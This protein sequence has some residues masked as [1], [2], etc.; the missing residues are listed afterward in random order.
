M[1]IVFS[2]ND[3]DVFQSGF[4]D[5][6]LGLDLVSDSDTSYVFVN[7]NG[8]AVGFYGT[9]LNSAPPLVSQINLALNGQLQAQLQDFSVDLFVL[10]DALNAGI[11]G[12]FEP[13]SNLLAE[14][15]T[16]EIDASNALV[17]YDMFQN[18][19]GTVPFVFASA[20]FDVT[21]SS[22]DDIL[23]DSLGN[24][25]ING[26][27]GEDDY[28]IL[29][30]RSE[31]QV[32][33]VNGGVRITIAINDVDIIRNVETFVFRDGEFTLDEV[34]N[35]IAQNLTGLESNDTLL[36][37]AGND[38]LSGAPGDD[39]VEGRAGSDDIRGN[40]GRDTLTGDLGND[41]LR[42]GTDNDRL[43]GGGGD[44]SLLG[45]RDDDTLLGGAGD[46][47]LKGG[48]GRDSLNGDAGNDFLKGGTD[49][50]VALGGA[51][52]D[53]LNGNRADDLLEGGLGNDILRGGSGDDALQGDAGDDFLKGGTGADVFVFDLGAGRDTV[54]DFDIAQDTLEISSALAGGAINS[55]I[56]ADLSRVAVGNVEIDFG[57]GNVI[58][59]AG[60]DTTEGLA[61]AIFIG[62]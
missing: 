16:L 56:E 39:R 57:G 20:K 59:L 38:T 36:G 12:D 61:E 62:L 37:G 42:G 25:T 21:G 32:D 26:G 19:G 48:G 31:A 23:F 4:F 9:N 55:D 18:L 52:N 44:D 8:Y 43:V 35:P 49:D 50:D 28:F 53:I 40:A 46:D 15:G 34:L 29:A 13:V 7:G 27:P 3:L 2:G 33:A 22:F 24:D 58:V 54:A 41:T 10:F 14:S 6:S 30:S 1:R 45:Q 47:R 51:G 17:G 11:G 60:L 5:V